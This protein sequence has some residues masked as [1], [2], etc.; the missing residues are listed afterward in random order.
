[1][2]SARSSEC[3]AVLRTPS[4]S[5]V[6]YGCATLSFPHGTQGT[7]AEGALCDNNPARCRSHG[8]GRTTPRR[9]FGPFGLSRRTNVPP[10]TVPPFEDGAF[11]VCKLQ[12]T[13][14]RSEDM[15]IGWATDYPY[16]GINLMTRLS[17]L[18]KTPVSRTRTATRTTG[19]SA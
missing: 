18:T 19:W 1:M 2:D 14:V 10:R 11:T 6:L 17:E 12:Y 13:S 16:A 7:I 4:P 3:P 8:R 5:V 15:G 9:G